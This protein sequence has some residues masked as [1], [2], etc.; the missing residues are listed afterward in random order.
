MAGLT[1]WIDASAGIAGDMLLG[2]LLDAGA[3]L[4][5]VREAVEAVAPG[6][7][8][9][10]TEQ[11]VRHGMRATKAHV[12]PTH[13]DPVPE[14]VEGHHHD[15]A[16]EHRAW[17]DIERMIR[18]AGLPKA[19]RDHSLA[20]FERIAVA[21]S[22]AH[23]VPVSEVH[24]HEVGAWDSI[25]DIVG[26][27]AALHSLG[28]ERI[29]VGDLS[30]GSGTIR[31]AHGEL[32]V[33]GPAVAELSIG[34]VVQPGPAKT[35]LATPTGVAFVA[36]QDQGAMPAMTVRATGTGAGT[37]DFPHHANV[38]RVVLGQEQSIGGAGR[39]SVLECNVDDLD[40]RLW[41]GILDALLAAGAKD[42]WLTP[43]LMKKGRPAHTLHVLT[44]DPERLRP[45]V[46]RHTTTLGIREVLVDRTALERRW[47]PVN[48]EG[49]VVQVKQGLLDGEVMTSQPEF[50]DVQAL[51]AALDIPEAEALRR[52][53]VLAAQGSSD[54]TR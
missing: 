26:G 42:A 17:V 38:V 37:K 23:G 22:R 43:I 32:A 33:P 25:A 9:I 52:V 51:A 41:P 29:V 6:E 16:H 36:G 34:L 53:N 3:S 13:H 48:I 28:V 8:T 20:V 31:M 2:A 5:A 10:S 47:V 18:T 7:V 46:F 1:C 49:H 40:P 4:D 30:V 54:A 44:D 14:L 24:F 45:L 15:H 12:S 19:V 21:E 35:E 11:V 50:R 39:L 27:C